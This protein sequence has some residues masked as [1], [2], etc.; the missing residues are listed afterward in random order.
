MT[1]SIARKQLISFFKDQSYDCYFSF[2]LLILR[3]ELLNEK[4]IRLHGVI[5]LRRHLS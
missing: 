1:V 5:F 2:D 4:L 3:G